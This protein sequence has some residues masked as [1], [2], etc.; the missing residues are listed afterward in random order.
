MSFKKQFI[1]ESAS[2]VESAL[3]KVKR[4]PHQFNKKGHEQQF[5]HQEA[6]LDKVGSA[7]GALEKSVIDVATEKK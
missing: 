3:K 5:R 4:D 2:S 7:K 6:I 1:D